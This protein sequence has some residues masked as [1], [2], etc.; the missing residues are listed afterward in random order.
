MIASLVSFI[1]YFRDPAFAA[2]VLILAATSRLFAQSRAMAALG[3]AYRILH[4]DGLANILGLGVCLT[5]M[6]AMAAY[7]SYPGYIDHLE[8]LMAATAWYGLQG[9]PLHPRLDQGLY[10]VLYGPAGFT[11]VGIGLQLW[12]S[13][14][15]SKIVALLATLCGILLTIL[16]V[17]RSAPDRGLWT[18]IAIAGGILTSNADYLLF[19]R[20]DPFLYALSALGVY[21]AIAWPSLI[22]AAVI[23]AAA[24][25]AANMKI[26]GFLY[27]L[28]A[29]AFV[30]AQRQGRACFAP[31]IVGIGCGALALTLPFLVP[32][33]SLLAFLPYLEM[34]THH[35]LDRALLAEDAGLCLALAV[36]LIVP[37]WLCKPQLS[38]ADRALLTSLVIS[39][40]V[41]TIIAAKPGAGSHH[42]YPFFPI[43]T[44]ALAR[45]LTAPSSHSEVGSPDA[46]RLVY[47]PLL[48]TFGIFGFL[49]L[50]QIIDTSLTERSLRNRELVE[51]SAIFA[52]RQNAQMGVSD[53]AHYD[54]TLLYPPMIFLGG[55]MQI[56]PSALMDLEQGG[57]ADGQITSFLQNC[58]VGYWIL[59]AAGVPFSLRNFYTRRPLFSS[60]FA[61]EFR[62]NYVREEAGQYYE[63]WRCAQS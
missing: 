30:V 42:L 58:R 43:V 13:I 31:A 29:A 16:A 51:L 32:G 60:A 14:A 45:I 56:V 4:G 7:L 37:L 24:G 50:K 35:G 10:G 40:A 54:D 17:R 59:P 52:H 39:L 9:A 3:R 20:P 48:F 49:T 8:P 12:P 21:A 41:V 18:R 6:A 34:A 62:R 28:P 63:V 2:A 38:R 5:F 22:A 23:G 1:L 26:H 27:L 44:V 33:A 46:L 61:K 55:K 19:N 15:G 36:P 11:L 57:I 53:A 47:F 25:L